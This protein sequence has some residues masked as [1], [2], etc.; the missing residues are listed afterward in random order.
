MATPAPL[1]W[2]ES[3]RVTPPRRQQK[4]ATVRVPGEAEL[5]VT[6]WQDGTEEV[7]LR[8]SCD[9]Q[10]HCGQCSCEQDHLIRIDPYTAARMRAALC[11]D[12]P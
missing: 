9:R 4:T 6:R 2:P 11:N 3:A 7:T 1:P 10:A 8:V 12:R 5:T